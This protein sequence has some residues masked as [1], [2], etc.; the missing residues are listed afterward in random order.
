MVSEHKNKSILI[1]SYRILSNVINTCLATV[2]SVL[3]SF[4]KELWV[5]I[6]KRVLAR[7]HNDVTIYNV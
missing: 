3:Q 1:S 4:Y 5:H 6:C 2:S 7:Q